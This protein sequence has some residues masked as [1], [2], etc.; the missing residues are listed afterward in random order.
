MGRTLEWAPFR[1]RQGV[2][3]MS[4]LV[5]AET[6]QVKFLSRQAG[7]LQRDLLKGPEDTYVDAIRWASKAAAEQALL[8]AES[9]AS[10]QRYF[11]LL[12]AIDT[13]QAPVSISHFE[14]LNDYPIAP[15]LDLC[16]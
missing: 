9:D 1:L 4:L 3:E 2:S 13:K 5:A 14:I 7:L 10:C 16:L 15:A 11:C 8:N 12:E 6:L